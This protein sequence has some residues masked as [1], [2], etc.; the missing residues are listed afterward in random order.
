P[1]NYW[2][3]ARREEWVKVKDIIPMKTKLN[4]RSFLQRAALT[5]G[6]LSAAQLFPVPNI[7]RAADPGK[8]H[9]IVQIGCGGRGLG[10]HIGWIL[11]QGTDDLVAIVDP[12]EKSH[13]Q[14]KRAMERAK[15]DASKLQ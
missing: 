1:A 7:L 5:T 8:R 2:I 6:A 11:K 13:G 12:D 9:S 3:C 14:V 4:R 10:T 15:V